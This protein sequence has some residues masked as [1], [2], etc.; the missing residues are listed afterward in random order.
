VRRYL[1]DIDM[2][3]NT[4]KNARFHPDIEAPSSP[5][6]GMFWT[7]T[8]VFPN[9]L[10]WYDG[11]K[12]VPLGVSTPDKFPEKVEPSIRITL[13]DVDA[14]GAEVGST[15][16]ISYSTVFHPGSYTYSNDT[17]VVLESL[18]VYDNNTPPHESSDASDTFEQVV[19]GDTTEYKI[20]VE[21]THSAGYVPL[22]EQGNPY[23]ES[24]ISAGTKKS[25]TSAISGFRKYFY[26]S[27]ISPIELNSGNIRS[28]THSSVPA[29]EGTTFD[30]DIS[31]GTN[32]VVIAFPTNLNLSLSSVI[33][34]GA[35]NIN[36]Y[37]VFEKVNVEVE[38]ANGYDPISYDVYVY[39]PDVSLSKNLYKVTIS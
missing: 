39:S 8:S 1:T 25:S 4:V 19:I 10:Y 29:S 17:G 13:S 2:S 11:E 32:Q 27:I 31:E 33:D 26:G 37:D 15:I 36:V 14:S 3:K 21:A 38:G 6:S 28:L 18:R 12:W 35:F 22:T 20:F 5:V 23:P 7:D 30:L 24:Q 34:T 16:P 9:K